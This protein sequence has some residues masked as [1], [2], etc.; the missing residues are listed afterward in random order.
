MIFQAGDLMRYGSRLMAA[1]LMA[2][3]TGGAPVFAQTPPEQ[4]QDW[5]GLTYLGLVSGLEA[6]SVDGSDALWMRAPDGRGLIRG[7]LFSAAGIDLGAALT[8]SSPSTLREGVVGDGPDWSVATPELISSVIRLSAEEAF[9]LKIGDDA[10]PEVWVWTDLA[11]PSTPATYMML[12]D[13]IEAGEISLRVI[14]VVTADTASSDLMLRAISQPGPIGALEGLVRGVPL[15]EGSQRDEERL[16]ISGGLISRIERNGQLAS[17]VNPPGLPFLVWDGVNGPVAFQ[18]IPDADLFGSVTPVT[19][20]D[21][22]A[23]SDASDPD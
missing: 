14:P 18:G 12:R 23:G 8:G 19:S 3:L 1:G 16:S 17:R 22:E 20:Q 4:I 11:D 13:L 21:K 2:L 7:D 15:P 10:A 6:W 5:P 9:P